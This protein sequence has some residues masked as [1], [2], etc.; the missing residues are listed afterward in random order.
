MIAL[1]AGW[2]PVTVRDDGGTDVGVICRYCVLV[3][4][5]RSDSRGPPTSVVSVSGPSHQVCTVE[6]P[7][8]APLTAS[9]RLWSFG[10]FDLARGGASGIIDDVVVSVGVQGGWLGRWVGTG[11]H[12]CGKRLRPRG[13]EI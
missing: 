2:P 5:V 3:L 13:A 4:R 1:A 9:Q 10:V 6:S 11:S 8:G 12:G 7:S